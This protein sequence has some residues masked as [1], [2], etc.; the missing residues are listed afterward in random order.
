MIAIVAQRNDTHALA[1]SERLKELGEKPVM[2]DV[3]RFPNACSATIRVAPTVGNDV[4]SFDGLNLRDI[5]SVWLRRLAIPSPAK[6]ITNADDNE[7]VR[8]NLTAYTWNLTR[9]MAPF[10]VNHPASI[11]E[12]DCGFGKVEQLRM[13][14]MWGLKIPDT[15]ITSDPAK[16]KAFASGH[17]RLIYK[18]LRSTMKRQIYTGFVESSDFEPLRLCPGIL[19]EYVEKRVEVRVVVCGRSYMATEIHSQESKVS[20]TDF[21]L[22]YSVPHKPHKLPADVEYALYEIHHTMNLNFGVH[23]LILTPKGEYCYLEVNQ[24]GQFLWLQ[25]KTKQ[26]YIGFVARFLR[27]RDPFYE[28]LS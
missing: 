28:G 7:F 10:W 3:H 13:A 16:A 14:R 21:R 26:D 6:S 20:K 8:G 25:D 27:S 17:E 4:A 19:Q 5:K 23:D 9:V 1:V 11:I 15:L 12:Q 22:D 18:P 2:I 24:Q